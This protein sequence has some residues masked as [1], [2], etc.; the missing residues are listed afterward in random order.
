MMVWNGRLPG[1][2]RLGLSG[3]RLKPWPAVLHRQ[4]QAGHDHAG[5]EPHVVALDEAH[6]H[7][8][9]VSRCEVDRAAAPVRIAGLARFERLR[10]TRVDQAGTRRQ[11]GLV[12]QVL[13]AHEHPRG[14]GDLSIDVGEGQLHRLDLQMLGC[15]AVDLETG[16]VEVLEDAQRHQGGDAL[17]VRRDLVQRVAAVTA[18]DR[19]DPV[20]AVGRQIGH[21]EGATVLAGVVGHGLCQ[22]TAV[23]GFAAGFGDAPQRTAGCRKAKNTRRPQAPARAA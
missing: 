7:A 20:G 10:A 16:Q 5:T 11:V 8:A 12:E 21:G 1:A 9:L 4:A 18:R 6:H 2:T 15:R 13:H 3:S 19:R 23:E 22:I 17:P 14:V